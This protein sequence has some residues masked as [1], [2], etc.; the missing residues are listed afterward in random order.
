MEKSNISPNKIILPLSGNKNGIL[1]D[2]IQTNDKNC[3]EI[4]TC[5]ICQCLVWDPVCCISC[6]KSFCRSCRFQYGEKKRCPFKCDTYNLREITRNEKDYLNKIS[7]R[8]TNNGCLKFIKYYDYKNHLE[9][10][11]FRK[12]HCKNEPCK[13]EG[14]INDMIIHSQNCPYRKIVCQKCKKY[15][16][17]CENDLHQ[18]SLCS[19]NIVKCKFC[20]SSMKRGVYLKEH[21]SKNN[22]NPNCLK[23]QLD[24]MKAFY[25]RKLNEKRTIINNLN[26]KINTLEKKKNHYKKENED[27]KKSVEEMKSFFQNGYNKFI[28]QEKN[29]I[30]SHEKNEISISQEKNE[31]NI[32]EPLNINFEIKNIN[33]ADSNIINLKDNKLIESSENY[34]K[35]VSNTAN[36]FY[37]PNKNINSIRGNKI[38]LSH[39][40]KK[41]ESNLTNEN[42]EQKKIEFSQNF[43]RV[44]SLNL[45]PNYKVPPQKKIILNKKEN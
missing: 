17:Y 34:E 44:P 36:N 19:E 14:F 10:C 26:N 32:D 18:K 1:D 16:N 7:I 13:E 20:H 35:V 25:E 37:R 42:I 29:E 4:F 28:S 22:S 31:I 3:Q 41:K 39:T 21:Q 40:D 9:K 12:Y 38:F 11:E 8:C 43:K 6:D 5:P 33:L 45:L 2:Y 24:N 15:I 30:I 23:I 27:L